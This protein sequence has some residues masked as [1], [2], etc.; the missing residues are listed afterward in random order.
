[1]DV[2]VLWGYPRKDAPYDQDSHQNSLIIRP[3]LVGAFFVS[4]IDSEVI[5]RTYRLQLML[6]NVKKYL[7]II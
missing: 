5:R 2:E 7:N 4:T 6:D 3:I 1:M